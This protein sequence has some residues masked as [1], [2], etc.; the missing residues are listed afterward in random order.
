MWKLSEKNTWGMVDQTLDA[1]KED[2]FVNKASEGG[3]RTSE[4]RLLYEPRQ[5]EK[6]E[7]LEER[8]RRYYGA[9]RR[10]A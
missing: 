3:N 4:F 1:Q 6:S 2:R 8:A 9:A 5:G 10:Y 7:V